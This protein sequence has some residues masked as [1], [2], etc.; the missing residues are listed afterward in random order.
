MTLLLLLLLLLLLVVVLLLVVLEVFSQ[1]SIMQVRS[2][3]ETGPFLIFVCL[4]LWTFFILDE[5]AFLSYATPSR[6]F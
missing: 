1:E 4:L 5:A 6:D 2:D 3:D